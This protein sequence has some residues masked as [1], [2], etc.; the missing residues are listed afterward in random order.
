[1]PSRGKLVILAMFLLALVMGGY[2]WW[3][4]RQKGHRSHQFWGGPTALL[5]R[6]AAQVQLLWLEPAGTET[7]ARAER[8]EIG[9]Q[10][11]AV[12]GRHEISQARGLVHARYAL[13]EDASFAWDAPRGGCENQWRFALRFVHQGQS[14]TVAFDPDCSQLLLVGDDRT[15]KLVPQIMAAF[16]AKSEQWRDEAEGS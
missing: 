1:M 9:G 14:A 4:Q 8:L 16:A 13:I 2:A 5:I 15:I 7:P 10:S 6:H 12:S 11:L 3:H